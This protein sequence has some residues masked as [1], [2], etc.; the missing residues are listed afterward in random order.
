MKALHLRS[1]GIFIILLALVV[2]LAGFACSRGNPTEPGVGPDQSNAGITLPNERN[3][4]TPEDYADHQCWGTFTMLLDFDTGTIEVAENRELAGHLNVKNILMNDWWCPTKNCIQIQFLEM[5]PA[6][7]H[8]L[9]KGTLMNPTYFTGYDVRVIIFLDEKGHQLLNPDDYTMLYEDGDDINP[10]RAYNKTV[11]GRKFNPYSTSSEIFDMHVPNVPHKFMIDFAIDASFPDNCIEPYDLDEF[12]YEGYIYKDDPTLDGIDQGEGMVFTKV[13]DWLED[14]SEVTV[15]T[16]PVTGGITVLAYNEDTDRWEGTIT[17]SE[18]ADMGDYICLIAAYSVED[19][20]LGLYNYLV[21]TVD[22]TPPPAVQTIWGHVGDAHYMTGL[23]GTT[24]S[25]VPQDPLGYYPPPV[26]VVD[27]EYLVNVTTGVYNISVYT[28]DGV[29]QS[30]VAN[31][32]IVT[33]NEDV[34]LNFGLLY[35]YQPD[36][37]S[38]YGGQVGWGSAMGF[39]GRVVDPLGM[40]I[41]SATIEFTSPDGYVG[42]DFVMAEVSDEG[43]YFSATN[44]PLLYSYGYPINTYHVKVRADGYLEN[45]IGFFPAQQ[46]V[47]PYNVVTL[48]SHGE[49]PVWTE[50]FEED[51]GWSFSGFYHRQQYNPSVVNMS[52]SP[53]YN[54]VVYPPDECW[55]G[56]IPLPTDGDY[57]LWYGVEQDGNILGYWSGAAGGPYSGGTGDAAHS[58]TATGPSID[59]TPYTTAR[60]E[61]DMTYSMESQDVPMFEIMYFY[62]N[63]SAVGF[64]NPFID[65]DTAA[66]TFTQRGH[67]RTLIWCHYVHDITAWA[68]SSVTLSF[69]FNTVDDLYNGYRGQFI[70]NIKI[71]AQ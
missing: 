30:I 38:L 60:V 61:F 70:D 35:P 39:A 67:N 34:H 16:T 56:A 14:I 42:Q 26:S 62:V 24:V 9:I 43:G 71:Y 65:G 40:P 6:N 52:F 57:Y 64:Y 41:S 50:S 28:D 25:V 4:R 10:F 21:V 49:T 15:D 8:Y 32:V 11:P 58:G 19:P 1:S 69:S 17:N 2:A 7:E 51:T 55:G 31:D 3:A 63:G 20:T 18:D 13:Y 48:Q 68:G 22:E 37:Y 47:V 27:G 54:L 46:N 53:S 45:D 5:D 59:L 66:Y 33:T 36:I 23:D 29:H 44:L 12:G